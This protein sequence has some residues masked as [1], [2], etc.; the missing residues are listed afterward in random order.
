LKGG[1]SALLLFQLSRPQYAS[2]WSSYRTF[3]GESAEVG[4]PR[5]ANARRLGRALEGEWKARQAR[6]QHSQRRGGDN[7][8]DQSSTAAAAINISKV[9]GPVRVLLR[10][11]IDGPSN[12]SI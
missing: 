6:L 7:H 4:G 3:N 2:K 11:R 8:P 10:A 12:W 1:H 5:T 9:G